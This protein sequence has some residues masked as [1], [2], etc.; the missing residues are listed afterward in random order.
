MR[1]SDQPLAG[2]PG[3]GRSGSPALALVLVAAAAADAA[4]AASFVV[5]AAALEW[6]VT[7]HLILALLLWSLTRTA[8]E[9]TTKVFALI[10]FL[11]A[12]P[13]GILGAFYLW[14]VDRR[15]AGGLGKA[16]GMMREVSAA[17]EDGERAAAV[18]Q[19]FT[20]RPGAESVFDFEQVLENGSVQQIQTMLGL[21]SQQFRP[22]YTQVLRRALRSDLA[23]VRVSAATV[24]SKLREQD[25]KRAV[26]AGI[27]TDV[28]SRE[29]AYGRALILAEIASNRLLDE[30]DIASIR[31][32]AIRLLRD[33]RPVPT[34]ADAIEE[35]LCSL[36]FESGLLE[37]LDERIARVGRTR[38]AVLSE[39]WLRA[40][41]PGGS[42]GAAGLRP[43]D[44][45][46]AET[47]QALLAETVEANPI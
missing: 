43:A 13:V 17:A 33:L 27:E 15:A 41:L 42:S 36:L 29:E 34:V 19:R 32:D 38:S 14:Q 40:F 21:I 25:R 11:L 26:A 9:M 37:E 44:G 2:N 23:A 22:E 7:G 30:R 10:A 31:L 3:T 18:V 20:A 5:G 8:Q 24:F 1:G 16:A 45:V 6:V 46:G 12:G 35:L 47:G 4:L 39:L 28:Q